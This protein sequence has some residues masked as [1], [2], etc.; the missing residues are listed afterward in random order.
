MAAVVTTASAAAVVAASEGQHDPVY[1]E[2]TDI[3]YLE[4]FPVQVQL[5]VEGAVPS[6]CHAPAW[7]VTATDT[8]VEIA[9]WSTADPETLCAAVLE[10]V[11]VI[12]PLGSWEAANL[13]V[14]LN[15]EPAGHIEIGNDADRVAPRLTGAGWSFG[16]CLGYC[17]A[18]L[19]IDG[20][21]LVQTGHDREVDDALYTNHGQLTSEG[22]A[23]LDAALTELADT[24]LKET[25]GCPDCAD[26]GAAYIMLTAA[27]GETRHDMEF[28]SPPEELSRIYD[29]SI[30]LMS[31]LETCR[32]DDLVTVSEECSAYEP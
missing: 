13:D 27:D 14:T 10:P 5:V 7:E 24:P 22:Q 17:R 26:G 28:A 20:E 3:L 30:A 21:S 18:D 16:M 15:G 31:T 29:L 4:S 11:E 1:V 2:S 25:Y 12:I 9:L 19:R 23:R 6:P 32:S 8:S